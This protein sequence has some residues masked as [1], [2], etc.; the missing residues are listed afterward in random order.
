MQIWFIKYYCFLKNQIFIYVYICTLCYGILGD[1]HVS[2]SI[3]PISEDSAKLI[4]GNP[5]PVSV[6][7]PLWKVKKWNGIF[8]V[9]FFFKHTSSTIYL[10]LFIKL[11]Y[12]KSGPHVNFFLPPL[13]NNMGFLFNCFSY[14]SAV[15]NKP[16]V[17]FE[18]RE[19]HSPKLNPPNS[20]AYLLG[21]SPPKFF[22][23]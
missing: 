23:R 10:F 12:V 13:N 18:L 17:D 3:L 16:T 22:T 11:K 8:K 7:L 9:Y 1:I 6:L 2:W 4:V 19:K 21:P 14:F 15:K 20:V 5:R